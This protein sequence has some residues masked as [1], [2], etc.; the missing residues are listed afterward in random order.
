MTKFVFILLIPFLF[1]G[2]ANRYKDIKDVRELEQKFDNYSKVVDNIKLDND[3][4]QKHL[5]RFYKKYYRP[6][7]TKKLNYNKKDL[8]WAINQ[9]P[10]RV[11]YGQ[12]HQPLP[13]E[14]WYPI[15]DNTN[16]KNLESLKQKA[17]TINN[18][19]IRNFPTDK[20]FFLDFDKA[21]EGYP[22]DYNQNS[23]LKPNTPLFVSHF[24]KDFAYAFVESPFSFGWVKSSDIAFV[25][26]DF[27]DK[28][29]SMQKMVAIKDN[30]ATI[31]N[32]NNFLYYAKVSTIFLKDDK[33]YT[34]SKEGK[35]G[36]FVELITNK[37]N[38]LDFPIKFDKQNVSNIA[39]ELI[40]EMYG[41]GE[42]LDT[43]DCSAMTRDFLKPFG[44]WLPRNSYAQAKS[45]KYIDLSK[46]TNKTK[47]KK[48]IELGIPFLST[49]YLRGH[50]MLYIGHI[51]DKALVFHNTWGI[52][53][54]EFL[55]FGRKIVGKSVVTT[56]YA[57]E[58]LPNVAENYILINR[59]KGLTIY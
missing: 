55:N 3:Y 50:I 44:I 39:N 59:I 42:L 15:V 5:K 26:S 7:S 21:G 22:F 57:G 16:M 40:G 23:G 20:P 13:K 18:T 17:I 48:I 58:E 24:S 25:D 4:F 12:N 51:G 11:M 32:K 6:W 14:W 46:L 43:R 56:L 10:K 54:L 29:K 45:A 36:I 49:I 28:F 38:L 37:N 9:Y 27:I 1:F 33:I 8:F 34:V 19:A 30:F 52:K 53:T 47:E 2:C 31:D 35:N 41:W